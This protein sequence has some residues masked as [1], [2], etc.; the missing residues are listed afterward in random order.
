VS[1]DRDVTRIV[2][3]WL[4]EDRHEDADRVLNN[5]L[6]EI[7][8]TPRRRS[9]W[10]ARRFPIMNNALRVG[11]AAVAVVIIA[12]VGYRLL[13]SPNVAGPGPTDT[14]QPTPSLA[15]SAAP[16]V[17]PLHDGAWLAPGTYSVRPQ[18]INAPRFSMT[19][20]AGWYGR[21][22]GV[23]KGGSIDP[24]DGAGVI[25]WGGPFNVYTNPCQW[26]DSPASP[27]TGLTVDDLIAGLS[28]QA[29]RDATAPTDITV[30]GFA[31]KAI[32][33]T[34]PAGLDFDSADGFV[35][36]DEG[37]FRSWISPDGNTFRLHQGPGQHDQLWVV[38]VDGTRVIIDATFYEGTSPADM[39]EIQAILDSI[40]LE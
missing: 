31:G 34:V 6:A 33:L 14:P 28:D 32:E 20:P 38:D 17:P 3:S 9:F 29:L 25:L 24:P 19:V 12:F 30:D 39:A 2:R 18:D 11:L 27:S 15:P 5:V 36:C 16:S 40:R 37:E 13:S 26:L 10:S 8:T 21:G 23:S 22:S 1:T 4:N 7:E 35:A